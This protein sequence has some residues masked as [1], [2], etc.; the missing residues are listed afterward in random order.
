M[1]TRKSG[2]YRILQFKNKKNLL[3]D[4]KEIAEFSYEGIVGSCHANIFV[5]FFCKKVVK[6]HKCYVFSARMLES[7]VRLKVLLVDHT[8]TEEVCI[9]M[10]LIRDQLAQLVTSRVPAQLDNSR[11]P[12]KELEASHSIP[13]EQQEQNDTSTIRL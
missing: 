9:N 13:G 7:D 4:E 1:Q 12:A 5:K 10:D 8:D 2:E 3:A 6:R 11:V